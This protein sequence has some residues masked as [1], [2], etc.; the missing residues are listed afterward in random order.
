MI[1]TKVYKNKTSTK[2]YK[3][4][5]KKFWIENKFINIKITNY[6]WVKI[7]QQLSTSENYSF[8]SI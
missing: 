1:N 2:S 4:Y 6:S 7:P 8:Y 5:N 3:S